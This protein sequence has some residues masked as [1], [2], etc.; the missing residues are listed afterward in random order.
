MKCSGI[1]K[2]DALLEKNLKNIEYPRLNKEEDQ[3]HLVVTDPKERL[4]L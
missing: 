3:Y 1:G 2:T 4:A